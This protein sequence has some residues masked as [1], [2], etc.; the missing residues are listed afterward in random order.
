MG[1]YWNDGLGHT[2]GSQF[3]NMVDNNYDLTS[4]LTTQHG[5][6]YNYR[7]RNKGEISRCFKVSPSQ[8]LCSCR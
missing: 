5:N 6:D 8:P 2:G 3:N 4:T 1:D 7:I